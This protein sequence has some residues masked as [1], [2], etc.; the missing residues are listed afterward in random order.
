MLFYPLQV[1]KLKGCICF[2]H[3][4]KSNHSYLFTTGCFTNNNGRKI[5]MDWI[6]LGR[7]QLSDNTGVV[8]IY[9]RMDD[10]WRHI[11]YNY[12]TNENDM[13][14]IFLNIRSEIEPVMLNEVSN[15][16]ETAGDPLEVSG[17]GATN[18][19][20]DADSPDRFHIATL[21][22]VPNDMCTVE[23]I[24]ITDD[25]ICATSTS[26]DIRGPCTGDVVRI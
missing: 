16:P 25:M 18:P 8:R 15:T 7:Q 10:V 20:N 3:Q 1:S 23:G 2:P 5:K 11:H 12:M 17:W 26:E 24:D 14:L 4:I 22:Y 6:D 21:G 13:A 9:P 19:E